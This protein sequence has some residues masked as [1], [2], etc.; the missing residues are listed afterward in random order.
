MGLISYNNPNPLKT[1]MDIFLHVVLIIIYLFSFIAIVDAI[2]HS[3]TSEGAMAWTISLITLPLLSLPCYILFGRRTYDKYI[4]A[5]QHAD[6]EINF[7]AQILQKSI[8]PYQY[9]LTNEENKL[10]VLQNLAPLPFTSSNEVELLIDG[11]EAFPAILNSLKNAKKYIIIQFYIVR[12][13]NI[14]IE[15]QQL[16]INRAR[17][18]VDIYFLYDRDISIGDRN[19]YGQSGP[20]SQSSHD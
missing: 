16:L 15:I 20:H 14:G 10:Q 18:G 3:R 13:D 1:I 19:P 17:E 8:Q 6:K 11:K 5:R 12:H 7:T 2:L 9:P 4:E